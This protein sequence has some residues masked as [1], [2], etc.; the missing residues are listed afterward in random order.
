MNCF[1]NLNK[2][3]I[4]THCK[5]KRESKTTV[6]KANVP[7]SAK[8]DYTCVIGVKHQPGLTYKSCVQAA[9]N[10]KYQFIWNT[11]NS[12]ISRCKSNI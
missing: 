4:H 3:S 8:D 6:C 10:P 11:A 7:A 1:H 5:R 2:A 12:P 9:G